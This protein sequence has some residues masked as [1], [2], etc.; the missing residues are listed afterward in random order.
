MLRDEIDFQICIC[1]RRKKFLKAPNLA[2]SHERITSTIG[3]TFTSNLI[4]GDR[5]DRE[6]EI[7]TEHPR[8]G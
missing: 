5:C 7:F 1:I 4:K 6:I 3:E 8:L 2:V